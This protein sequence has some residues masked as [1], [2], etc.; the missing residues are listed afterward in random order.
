MSIAVV[1]SVVAAGACSGRRTPSAREQ[2][3]E[4]FKIEKNEYYLTRGV[5]GYAIW[6]GRPQYTS[7]W[8]KKDGISKPIAWGLCSKDFEINYPDL[9]L[10]VGKEGIIM[11]KLPIIEKAERNEIE[12]SHE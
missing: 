7:Q 6:K 10:P 9:K 3:E 4:D 2:K 11:I 1:A 5:L 8:K 12:I